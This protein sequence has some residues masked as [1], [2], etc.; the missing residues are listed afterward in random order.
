M[1][2]HFPDA[3]IERAVLVMDDAA[4]ARIESMCGDRP[5]GAMV[6]AY[7]AFRGDQRIGT[8]Y[9]DIHPV[10]TLPQTLLIV[11]DPEGRLQ[12]VETIA[13]REPPEYAAPKRWLDQFAGRRLDDRLQ[14]KQGVHGITGATLTAR[15]TTRCVRRVLATH[16]VLTP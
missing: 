8:A 15:A 7:R 11:L 12:Q 6:I 2:R 4:R 1:W 10:R 9:F 5:Q 3:R 14:L 13:F 16:I